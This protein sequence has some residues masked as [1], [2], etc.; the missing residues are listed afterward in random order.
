MLNDCELMCYIM[1][2][3]LTGS[4]LGVFFGQ[5]PGPKTGHLTEARSSRPSEAT[6]HCSSAAATRYLRLGSDHPAGGESGEEILAAT[7]TKK[8]GVKHGETNVER[9]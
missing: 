1:L 8:K 7:K 2:N 3:L 9:M 4:F 5:F 6:V